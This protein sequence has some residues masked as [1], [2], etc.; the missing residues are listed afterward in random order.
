MV[1]D[2]SLRLISPTA[3]LDRQV[4]TIP[5]AMLIS[6]PTFRPCTA[7]EDPGLDDEA[8]RGAPGA[9]GHGG[10]DGR[11]G[12]RR[13]GRDGAAGRTAGAHARADDRV[14]VRGP[15]RPGSG[16]PREGFDPSLP[17]RQRVAAKA[18]ELGI[19]AQHAVVPAAEMAGRRV[20]DVRPGRQADH[21]RPAVA[22]AGRRRPADHRGDHGAARHRGGRV[23][24]RHE[25]LQAAGAEPAGRRARQGRG[26]ASRDDD[27]PPVDRGDPAGQAHHRV[28]GHPPHDQQPARGLLRGRDRLPRRRGRH[29]RHHPAGRAVL[30]PRR[31]HHLHGRADHRDR[32]RVQD[33]SWRGGSS[34]RAPRPP[35]PGR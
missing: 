13:P 11:A 19:G 27:L 26:A 6:D 35:T 22:P 32:R 31:G 24:R 12:P 29:A 25:P 5:L 10:R 34:P 20:H 30:R 1:G 18:A 15:G 8:T 17:M 14:P 9:D 21:D 23:D 28:G 33:R 4:I 2:T 16:E 3:P 7:D